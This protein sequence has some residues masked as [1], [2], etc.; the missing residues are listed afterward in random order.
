[1]SKHG[2]KYRAA[3][4]KLDALKLYPLS[5]AI[6]LALE[7]STTK[8]DSS[9]EIHMH[10]GIDPKQAEQQIRTTV[11][12][13]HGT[14]KTVRVVAFVSDDKV[15]TCKDAGAIEAGSAELIAKIEKGWMDFDVAVAT[16]EMMKELGKIARTLGQAGKMPNP[17]A[18]TVTP[19]PAAAVADVMKGQVEFRNDKLA[20]LHNVVGKVSFGEQK[21][22]ENVKAYLLAVMEK[23]PST[24]KGSYVKS[25]TLAT[26]MGPGIKVDV[27]DATAK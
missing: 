23:K 15:K 2:K 16:P 22:L 8:F 14:G 13:P 25:I 9:V 12:L 26:T 21:L 5:E 10:L 17:K 20:N 4:E 27:A 19:D 6:K 11:S 1:M 7:T 18:G 24:M 3:S